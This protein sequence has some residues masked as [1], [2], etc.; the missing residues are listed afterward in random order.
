MALVIVVNLR[1]GQLLEGG[2]LLLLVA[3]KEPVDGKATG[4]RQDE[5]VKHGKE[6]IP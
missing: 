4:R 3:D 6:A 1:D 2:L 5:Q